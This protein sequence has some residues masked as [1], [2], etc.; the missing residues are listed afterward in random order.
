MVKEIILCNLV[1]NSG[2]VLEEL[3]D[4][5]YNLFGILVDILCFVGL[6]GLGRY[7]GCFFVGKI[8][9]DG[10]HGVNLVYLE[11]VIG[12]IILLL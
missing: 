12:V 1:I 9:F 8:V 3:E 4:W 6:V 11:D 5:L 10:E 2:W 7:L